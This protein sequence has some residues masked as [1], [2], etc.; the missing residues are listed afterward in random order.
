MGLGKREEE[1]YDLIKCKWLFY[2]II[3]IP[4]LPEL[5]FDKEEFFNFFYLKVIKEAILI[6]KSD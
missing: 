1:M 6:R 4:F 3:I 5:E 2:T